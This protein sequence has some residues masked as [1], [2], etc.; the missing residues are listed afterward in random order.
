[1]LDIRELLNASILVIVHYH[2]IKL[3]KTPQTEFET[4]RDLLGKPHETM[5][6]D[7]KLLIDAAVTTSTL[8]EIRRP[9]LLFVLHNIDLLR[10]FLDSPNPLEDEKLTRI[11]SDLIQFM[12][13]IQRLLPLFTEETITY[14]QTEVK[15]Y[16]LSGRFYGVSNSG[17]VISD[18]LFKRLG[19]P[20][21]AS[22]EKQSKNTGT[23]TGENAA[24]TCS[25]CKPSSRG[26]NNFPKKRTE[27]SAPKTFSA[28]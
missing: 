17:Q 10:S 3:P 9:L 22:R 2:K 12:V 4:L 7:L 1:M 21:D 26:C 19:L 18:T 15:I 25:Y 28:R 14:N 13:D 16:G 8:D 11:K 23:R 5:T 24:T 20:I 6:S 27:R